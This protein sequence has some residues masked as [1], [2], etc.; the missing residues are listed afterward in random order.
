MPLPRI[1]SFS[2]KK[3][4]GKTELSKICKKYGY[5]CLNFADGLKNIVCHCLNIT[6]DWLELYKDETVITPYILST[7]QTIEYINNQTGISND[8]L[9]ENLN[10]KL[11]YSIR[12]ILQFLGTDI[13]RK[14]NPLWHINQLRTKLTANT[15]KLFCVGDIRFPNE[16]KLIDEL[17]GETWCIVRPNYD[18]SSNTDHSSENSLHYTEFKHVFNNN[19]SKENFTNRWEKYLLD[20]SVQKT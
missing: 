13:I 3:H 6:E 15:D 1:I 5:Q 10:S 14:Y 19:S 20:C 11:F 4:S 7:V 16:K 9:A 8:V 2:G 18:D 17:Q 12:E